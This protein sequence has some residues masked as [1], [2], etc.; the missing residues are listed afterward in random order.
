MK[1]PTLDLNQAFEQLQEEADA[2]PGQVKEARRRRDLFRD[3]FEGEDD[4]VEVVAS[5]SLARSTHRDPIN[6]V[7]LI[8]VFDA[9]VHPSWG[10]DGD[11]AG[12]ALE[13]TK[14]R[15][16]S[17]L[18]ASE[19]TFDQVVRLASPRNHAVKCFLDDPGEPD[20]F[21]VDVM[22]ALRH[23]E[24]GVLAPE[25]ANDRWIRTDPE[26][27]I[28]QVA[29]RQQAWD[30]FR[31]LVRV[32]KMWN[33]TRDVGLKSLAV[34][35]LALTHLP[36]SSNRPEALR[37]FFGAAELAIGGPIEDPAGLCDEIQPDRDVDQATRCFSEAASASWRAVD[38][39]AQGDT[40]RAACLWREV[41]GA[42]FPEPEGGCDAQ[43]DD[44]G[45]LG[46]FLI[47]TTGA[48]GAGIHAPRPV[49][50]SPQGC[51]DH[52]RG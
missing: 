36:E 23:P 10:A 25:K 32:L 31:P 24:R 45:G 44:E 38:A 30:Q 3:A 14:E 52:G 5:G 27:L 16:R 37:L 21:T 12:E 26:Y 20:A 9:S 49:V 33:T 28:A 11:S 50:D 51:G 34:E 39:Q 6:D 47:G 4:V 29:S 7:D 42:S 13:F 43:D 19:G 48:A 15:V 18:G 1:G 22:P 46:S 17:L 8:V 35:V 40:D 41:F 2:D